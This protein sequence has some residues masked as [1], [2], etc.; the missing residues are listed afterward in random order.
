MD[1]VH[2]PPA[3]HPTFPYPT[4]AQGADTGGPIRY[5]GDPKA[6]TATTISST[7]SMTG[8]NGRVEYQNKHYRDANYITTSRGGVALVYNGGG[9]PVVPNSAGAAGPVPIRHSIP[10][11]QTSKGAVVRQD[12]DSF[13]SGNFP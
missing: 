11:Q 8:N 2:G 9:T 4:T 7:S 6:V 5:M 3:H 10:A 13:E 1:Q 12:S